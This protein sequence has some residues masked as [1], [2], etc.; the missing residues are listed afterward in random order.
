MYFPL[1]VR[2]TH[3]QR[4]TRTHAHTQEMK[5]QR[6][7]RYHNKPRLQ[8]CEISDT[9]VDL[10]SPYRHPDLTVTGLQAGRK[11]R[12]NKS[13]TADPQQPFRVGETVWR[14]EDV[15]FFFCFSKVHRTRK[16]MTMWVVGAVVGGAGSVIILKHVHILGLM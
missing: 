9:H 4:H 11:P 7:C 12:Q 8:G 2:N 13:F 6:H 14:G 16:M 3:T 5:S 1:S 15:T 10:R